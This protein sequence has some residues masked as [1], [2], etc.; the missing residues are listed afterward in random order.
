MGYVVLLALLPRGL[1][2]DVRV[3]TGPH[4]ICHGLIEAVRKCC[5]G[6]V[7][8]FDSIMEQRGDHLVFRPPTL[9]HD[10]CHTQE[11]G[12]IGDTRPPC[13]PGRGAHRLRTAGRR[14]TSCYTPRV[15]SRGLGFR[16]PSIE[17]CSSDPSVCQSPEN[18]ISRVAST[19]HSHTDDRP[20]NEIRTI[21]RT[22]LP[23]QKLSSPS[24]SLYMDMGMVTMSKKGVPRDV[25]WAGA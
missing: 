14:R 7:G 6:G 10:G 3:R 12:D 8:V 13:G 25:H 9:A 4:Y 20:C 17:C 21:C 24:Q 1:G 11:V 16:L 23:P 18:S 2:S 5:V 15:L 19:C 22:W